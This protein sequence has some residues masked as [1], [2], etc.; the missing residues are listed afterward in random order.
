MIS[1]PRSSQWRFLRYLPTFLSIPFFRVLYLSIFLYLSLFQS[2]SST[3]CFFY[4][5]FCS[6]C[7]ASHL[8]LFI[9]HFSSFLLIIF[10]EI[11]I[12][13]VT[14]LVCDYYNSILSAW[15][16]QINIFASILFNKMVNVDITKI[17]ENINTFLRSMWRV[18]E[19]LNLYFIVK[20]YENFP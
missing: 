2:F 8:F 4:C 9:F 10:F 19:S 5:L 14:Y 3:L 17:H 16:N 20:Y 1:I 11:P 15:S 6:S 18:W 12:N 7:R 13:M